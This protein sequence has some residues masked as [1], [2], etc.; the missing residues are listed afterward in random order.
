[1]SPSAPF[2]LLGRTKSAWHFLKLIIVL[3]VI[4]RR[5]CIIGSVRQEPRSSISCIILP[6]W[7]VDQAEPDEGGREYLRTRHFVL[8]CCRTYDFKG[9]TQPTH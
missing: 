3:K 9:F 6:Q 2:S 7:H 1:M 8:R 4:L 5:G